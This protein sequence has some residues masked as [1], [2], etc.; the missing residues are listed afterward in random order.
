MPQKEDILKQRVVVVTLNTSQYL[1]QLDLEPGFFTHIL[2]DEAAQAMECETIMPL[3]L[4]SKNTRI[5]LAGDHMQ[6]SPFVYSEFARER[7]LH[8]SLLDR[9]YEHY[10]AEF[11]CRI[12]L[13]ENYR[14]H[15]AIINYTSE[16][17]YEGKLMASGKQPAHKDF[18]P[19]TFF[20]ARGEDVQEKNSTAFYNNAEPQINVEFSYIDAAAFEQVLKNRQEMPAKLLKVFEVVERVEE[21]RRKWPVA[22]GK[23]DDGSIG[24]VTPYADQVFRIR[25][26]LR[27]KRLSDVS[28]ERVLNVQGKQFRVLFLSTVRTRHTCKHKQT[29]IKRKEHLLEDSTEDLDYGFLSNYKL[30]N[31]AITRAQSLV[32]VVGDPIALCSIGR[33]RKFWERF[34]A[35]CHDNESLHG[36]TFDQIKAQLE[37]LELKKTYVLNPLAPEFIP[38]ALRQQHSSNANKSQQ[39]PPKVKGH[40]HNQNDHFQ[41]DGIVQPNPSVLIGNPIRAYTP[42]PPA[43]PPPGPHPNLGKSPSPVQRIDPHTGTSILYV[44]AVYGGNMVMSV[45]LPWVLFTPTIPPTFSPELLLHTAALVLPISQAE[46]GGWKKGVEEHSDVLSVIKRLAVLRLH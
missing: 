40:H 35:L 36:I 4:A 44:P 26:E 32:A 25:A 28:V 41:T 7:N 5:V 22:W 16:L 20:T 3:A 9:L 17:F 11:P 23:L 18:Y 27:K 12:L 6:L 34:I 31:T 30:L 37:A 14:S 39:S 38:R 29:P 8:V 19:L 2:L 33:C 24:V 1:C 43:P 10:P 45:P 21:L 13:C 42:P 15:E 46:D